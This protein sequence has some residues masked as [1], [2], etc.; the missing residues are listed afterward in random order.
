MSVPLFRVRGDADIEDT[1]T[2]NA[3]IFRAQGSNPGDNITLWVDSLNDLYFGANKVLTTTGGTG[4]TGN[5]GA[6]G[7]TGA[8]GA[9]GATGPTGLA[10][11]RFNTSTAAAVLIT[12]TEGGSLN[13][14][15]GTDL[16]YI[17]GNSIVVVSSA[18]SANRFEGTISSYNDT[19]GALTVSGITNIQGSFAATVVYNVNLDGIDGPTGDTGATGSTGPTGPTGAPGDLFN[20]A[21]TTAIILSPT[22]GGSENLTVST[23]PA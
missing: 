21:T 19:T 16:A 22:Q 1:I 2:T 10:G 8:T 9:T 5:T 3:S 12:P 20:T 23:V 11:D 15:V 14:T 18:N 17:P 7:P 13:L 6:T 4:P